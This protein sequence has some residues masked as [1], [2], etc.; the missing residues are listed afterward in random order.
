[1]KVVHNKE[2]EEAELEAVHNNLLAIA[3]KDKEE[4]PLSHQE[5]LQ[6][7]SQIGTVTGREQAVIDNLRRK[8]FNI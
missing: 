4:A 8:G 7:L 6:R 1:M 5:M 3:S 2:K